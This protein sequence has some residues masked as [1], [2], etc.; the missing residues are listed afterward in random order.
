MVNDVVNAPEVVGSLND[1]IYVYGF[2]SDAYGVGLEDVSRL[3]VGEFAALDVVGVVGEVN[4]CAVVYAAIKFCFL[5]FAEA[6]Q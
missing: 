5:F 3:L 1:I 2:I 6:V 4:L